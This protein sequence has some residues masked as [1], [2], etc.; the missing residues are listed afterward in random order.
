MASRSAKHAKRLTK[1]SVG[2]VAAAIRSTDLDGLA[3]SVLK[4]VALLPELELFPERKKFFQT[5]EDS[6]KVKYSKLVSSL[7][8][9]YSDLYTSCQGKNGYLKFQIKWHDFLR[10]VAAYVHNQCTSDAQVDDCNEDGTSPV[11]NAWLSL[12]ATVSIDSSKETQ[13][14]LLHAISRQVYHHM[15]DNAVTV[16]KT[17]TPVDTPL[18]PVNASDENSLDSLIRMCG[19]QFARI[20]NVKK[21]ELARLKLSSKASS[22]MTKN[23]HEQILLTESAC[24]TKDDKVQAHIKPLLPVCDEGGMWFPRQNLFPFLREFDM[25]ARQEINYHNFHKFGEMA[26]KSMQKKMGQYQERLFP[27]FAACFDKFSN[28]TILE[29][30]N[31]LFSKMV[32]LRKKDM[33]K[34]WERLDNKTGKDVNLNLRDQLKPY[35]K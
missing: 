31:L 11:A 22:D 16:I 5:V 25:I 4:E 34:S 27:L 24:M 14:S 23:I 28:P 13:F 33:E 1:S 10:S 12:I 20:H 3:E 18:I 30:Y 19:S 32:N 8:Q 2:K 15:H 35:A 6:C 9:K 17:S 29:V 26:F 21:K 7:C